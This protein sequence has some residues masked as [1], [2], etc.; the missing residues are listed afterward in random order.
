MMKLAKMMDLGE[1][2]DG[3]DYGEEEIWRMINIKNY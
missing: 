1:G 3:E 2:F